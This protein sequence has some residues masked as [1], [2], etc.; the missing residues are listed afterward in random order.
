MLLYKSDGF[1][2]CNCVCEHRNRI[3]SPVIE[4][5]ILFLIFEKYFVE[6]SPRAYE[7]FDVESDHRYQYCCGRLS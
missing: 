4:V 3:A 1:F 5:E 6:V 7:Y 2:V